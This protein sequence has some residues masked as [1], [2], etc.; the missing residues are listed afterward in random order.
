MAEQ[1]PCPNPKTQTAYVTQAE[2]LKALQ[3]LAIPQQLP[4]TQTRKI[5]AARGRF[6]KLSPQQ[7]PPHYT[8]HVPQLT[9]LMLLQHAFVS[10]TRAQPDPP[11]LD[12]ICAAPVQSFNLPGCC[13]HQSST[14]LQHSASA[15]TSQDD[16]PASQQGQALVQWFKRKRVSPGLCH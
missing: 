3:A 7:E 10:S 15:L 8:R 5:R 2:P 14:Q 16:A 4:E 12:V 13:G 1:S 6:A 11:I 9:T